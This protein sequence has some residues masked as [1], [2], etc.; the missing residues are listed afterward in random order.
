[1]LQ[2]NLKNDVTILEEV[3]RLL[4]DLRSAWN[5]IENAPGVQPQAAPQRGA[6]APS[7]PLTYA[8]A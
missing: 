5:A 2:A 4:G 3:Q 6:A 1:L 7:S 8:S